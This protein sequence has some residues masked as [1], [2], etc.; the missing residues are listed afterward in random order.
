MPGI[1]SLIFAWFFEHQEAPF[2]QDISGIESLYSLAFTLG[3]KYFVLIWFSV[4]INK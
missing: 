1:F 2:Y 4:R 3:F